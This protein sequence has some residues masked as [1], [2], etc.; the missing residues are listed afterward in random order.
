MSVAQNAFAEMPQDT[1]ITDAAASFVETVT[2]ADLPDEALRIGT[3]CLVDAFG[4]YAAGSEE[5]SVHILADE[6]A[7][8]GGRGD[9]LVLGRLPAAS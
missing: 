9:A 5:H 7:E 3:R 1:A 8:T 4:L 6:A 2:F